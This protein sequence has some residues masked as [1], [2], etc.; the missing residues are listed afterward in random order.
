M[1]ASG[2]LHAPAALSPGKSLPDPIW[3]L[4]RREKSYPCRESNPSRPDLHTSYVVQYITGNIEAMRTY[5]VV[6]T[7][8]LFKIWPDVAG[9]PEVCTF[10][11]HVCIM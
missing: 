3:T 7:L 9:I 1:E 6:T 10:L 4:W 8:S 11:E 2:Q 5:E